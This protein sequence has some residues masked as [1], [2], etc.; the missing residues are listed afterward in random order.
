MCNWY[1][2]MMWCIYWFVLCTWWRA[3]R[4]IKC[5]KRSVFGASQKHYRFKRCCIDPDTTHAY[6]CAYAPMGCFF[7]FFL[8]FVL[9]HFVTFF[10]FKNVVPYMWAMHVHSE[11]IY[12]KN[13][14]WVLL[15]WVGEVWGIKPKIT[16]ET[17]FF[18]MFLVVC[19]QK[20]ILYMYIISWN[21]VR[22]LDWDYYT[23]VFYLTRIVWWKRIY[24]THL[25][26][27]SWEAPSF[28]GFFTDP[29]TL[30]VWAQL[31]WK[32]CK[33]FKNVCTQKHSFAQFF[34]IF[35]IFFI[36][37]LIFCNIL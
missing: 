37:L 7:V 19:F 30:L 22:Y 20:H 2:Q 28:T 15:L 25:W 11:H 3:Q 17:L 23:C 14:G 13:R 27:V 26:V 34:T 32:L 16:L 9:T 12:D 36:F 21:I 6:D 10:V 35:Y 33:Y 31:Y 1:Q 8:V 29:F 4:A 24:D 5:I 18:F